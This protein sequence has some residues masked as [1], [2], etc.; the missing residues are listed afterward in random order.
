MLRLLV[1]VLAIAA[2]PAWG[3]GRLTVV[4]STTDLKSLVEAVGGDRVTVESLAP[5]NQDP[6]A[7]EIKPGQLARL[8]SADLLVR[9]G[10]DHE[11]WLASALRAL[12]DSRL[13]PGSRHY[14]DAS[15]GIELLQAETARV[16]S[17]R[18]VHVHGFGNTH[19]WLDP[20]NARPITAAIAGGLSAL[21]PGERAAFE[22]N[23]ARFLA[24]LDA[25]ITRWSRAMAPYRGTRVVVV[26]ESWPYFTRRFGLVT[27]A[28]VEPE[29]GIP[30]SPSWIADLTNR[31]RQTG[32][33]I[34]IAEP[35]SN[36]SLVDQV[37]ARSGATVVTLVSSV[38]GDPAATDYVALF[39]VNIARLTAA[40]GG[41]R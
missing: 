32:L 38:G 15:R 11:P 17:E 31:M 12:G 10:L 24:R 2:A 3:G 7:I 14:L 27:V 41:A 20:E 22:A 26:H 39:D 28:A 37:A 4:T 23:R 34:L 1:A 8:K 13:Q 21:T 25:G 40:L 29:P 35:A 5:A 36:A 16:K 18:G 9:V 33:K 6:H 19:Y 30:P